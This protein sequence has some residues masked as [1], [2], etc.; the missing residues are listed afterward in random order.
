MLGKT[1]EIKMKVAVVAE[2]EDELRDAVDE[3][4]KL[5]HHIDYFVDVENYP[6][7]DCIWDVEVR[8]LYS[9]LNGKV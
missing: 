1:F 7:I 9:E 3:L 2:N 5:E 4:K 8:Q 6:E